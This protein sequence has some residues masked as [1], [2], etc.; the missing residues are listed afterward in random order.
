MHELTT[1]ALSFPGFSPALI[2]IDLGFLG[3]GKFPI[4]WYALAYIAGLVIGWRYALALVRRPAS[5]T[6]GQRA[7]S[8]V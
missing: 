8:P 1:A 3:L 5:T 4:R 2:E 6:P 7:M